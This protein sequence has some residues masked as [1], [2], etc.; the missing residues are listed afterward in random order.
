MTH[1][2]QNARGF[3]RLLEDFP[4]KPGEYVVVIEGKYLDIW[5]YAGSNGWDVPEDTELFPSHWLELQYP[6]D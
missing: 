3:W 1:S 5:Y 2:K 4:E 6:V